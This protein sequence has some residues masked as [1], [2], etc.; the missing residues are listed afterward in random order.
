[1]NAIR[2][3]PEGGTIRASIRT[4]APGWVEVTVRDDGEG[5]ADDVREVAFEPFTRGDPARNVATGTAGLGLA[6]ARGIVEAHGG[7]IT[8]GPGP[9]GEITFRLPR[10][11]G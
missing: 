8:I 9:G 6:I 10:S 11:A 3:A 2:H 5:F 1:D 7:T 4:D